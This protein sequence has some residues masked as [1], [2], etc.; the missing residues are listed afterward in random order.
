MKVSKFGKHHRAE[1]ESFRKIVRNPRVPG[2]E[3]LDQER[4]KEKENL[5]FSEGIAIFNLFRSPL[6]QSSNL[7][8]VGSRKH[9]QV[10]AAVG[11]FECC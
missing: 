11:P 7:E 5:Y 4:N 3:C 10:D 8:E 2:K 6:D 1:W 9:T